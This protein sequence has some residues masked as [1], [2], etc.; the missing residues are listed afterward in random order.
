MNTHGHRM[1]TLKPT[2]LCEQFA[3]K[4]H[5]NHLHIMRGAERDTQRFID[6]IPS[7]LESLEI[8]KHHT[9]NSADI[10]YTSC[11]G[12]VIPVCESVSLTVR[13]MGNRLCLEK[14]IFTCASSQQSRSSSGD[15]YGSGTPPDCN[16]S[17]CQTH[18]VL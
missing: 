9:N 3:R 16:R 1:N 11:T 18:T 2:Q 10:G 17:V 12:P 8:F 13:S 14:G 7:A 4:Q 15:G 6:Q 5:Q